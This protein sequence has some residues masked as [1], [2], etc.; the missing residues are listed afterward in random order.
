MTTFNS[1]Q[2]VSALTLRPG[3]QGCWVSL[4]G[5]KDFYVLPL[6]NKVG[7]EDKRCCFCDKYGL[8]WVPATCPGTETHHLFWR[9]DIE[10]SVILDKISP[11]SQIDD[12]TWCLVDVF[13]NESVLCLFLAN[14][15]SPRSHPHWGTQ[16]PGCDLITT[17][18][19]GGVRR[20]GE[21][22][23]RNTGIQVTILGP[24]SSRQVVISSEGETEA[25]EARNTT[26]GKQNVVAHHLLKHPIAHL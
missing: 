7:P 10:N 14:L 8:K 22:R 1:Q 21:A 2:L 5:Q 25:R 17:W 26:Q 18:S 13:R 6:A 23:Y 11:N 4:A 9:T 3:R 20:L 15:A 24:P 16:V 19:E 12:K